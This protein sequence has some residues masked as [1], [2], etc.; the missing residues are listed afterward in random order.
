MGNPLISICIPAYKRVE[1]LSRLLN[2]IVSQK[3]ADFE[4]VVTDDSPDQQ[5]EKLCRSFESTLPITY[6]RNDQQL[7]TPGNWNESIRRARGQ[8]IKLM[9]DDD[10]FVDDSS[11]GKLAEATIDHSGSFIVCPYINVFLETGKEETVYPGDWRIGTVARYPQVLMAKNCIGPPSVTLHRNDGRFIYDTHTKWVVDIDFYIRRLQTEK[12]H[13]VKDPLVKVGISQEQVTF[14]CVR[15]ADVEI[16]ENF[17][18]FSKYDWRFLNHL[19]VYDFCWRLLRNFN[20]GTVEQIRA[21]GYKEDLPVV[22]H[23]I[24]GFQRRVPSFFLKRGV[25]SKGLMFLHFCFNRNKLPK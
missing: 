9:H 20:I 8:W 1:Y 6:F 13:V 11:L 2:S 16:P 21:A 4:V 5:V 10:W 7:G 12:L 3:F 25:I 24:I 18:L 22:V 15:H 14:S 19:L 23:H 17:Y